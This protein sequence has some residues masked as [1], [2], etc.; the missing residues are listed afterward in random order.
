MSVL[1]TLLSHL[2]PDLAGH[3]DY[4]RMS[5]ASLQL[6]YSFTSPP[7]RKPGNCYE[8]P[9]MDAFSIQ[10]LPVLLVNILPRKAVRRVI[11]AI[12]LEGSE[13]VIFACLAVWLCSKRE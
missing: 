1:R 3:L 13:M 6:A 9:L 4:L 11:D 7:F 5:S 10:W 2:L 8:P 12:L